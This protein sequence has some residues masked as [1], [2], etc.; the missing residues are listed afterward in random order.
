MQ[1]NVIMLCDKLLHMNAVKIHKTTYC[2]KH[3]V[4]YF[5]VPKHLL[6]FRSRPLTSHRP[7]PKTWPGTPS[8]F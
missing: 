6:L 5:K 8:L 3:L 1:L 2:T 7:F 4:K